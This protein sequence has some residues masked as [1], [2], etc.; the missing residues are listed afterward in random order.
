MYLLVGV[1]YVSGEEE[2]KTTRIIGVL[3]ENGVIDEVFGEEIK[4]SY[5]TTQQDNCDLV[6]LYKFKR[7]ISL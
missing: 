2:G 4:V 6:E 5:D 1:R 7:V 3:G